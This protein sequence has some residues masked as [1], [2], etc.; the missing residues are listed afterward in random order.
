[1]LKLTVRESGRERVAA[2][3]VALRK[4]AEPDS[5]AVRMALTQAAV[6]LQ[7]Q[8]KL[9]I[10]KQRL[11]DTG[12]LLNSIKFEYYKPSGGG[13]GVRVGSFGVPYAAAWEFGLQN[14]KENVRPHSR[15]VT[16]VW[17]R[18]LSSPITITVAG[19]VR[20]RNQ[21]ARPYMRPALELHKQRI[22]DFIAQSITAQAGA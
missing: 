1:M 3:L 22:V 18:Q 15:T 11:I 16:Q 10:R 9:E 20:T 19:F 17:G 6:L 7:N 5:P 12:R 14:Y 8:I 21:R 2:R 4:A 13:I